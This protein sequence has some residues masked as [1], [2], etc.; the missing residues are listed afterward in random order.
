M[1]EVRDTAKT[2]VEELSSL[3]ERRLDLLREAECPLQSII[4]EE[5]LEVAVMRNGQDGETAMDYHN[6]TLRQ[7]A[8]EFQLLLKDKH[9]KL[10]DLIDQWTHTQK[11]LLQTTVEIAGLERLEL[12]REQ[13][14]SELIAA[15]A[16]GDK[17]R[18]RVGQQHGEVLLELEEVERQVRDVTDQTK[19]SLTKLA[20]VLPLLPLFRSGLTAW[21]AN[22]ARSIKPDQKAQ[23]QSQR[24]HGR[25]MIAVRVRTVT[26][27]PD[28]PVSA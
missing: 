22:S 2:H 8:Q 6:V 27:C 13:A 12:K 17:E 9:G 14:Y 7:R 16:A 15:L 5:V 25:S 4:S 26:S 3:F 19:N 11:E 10:T 23:P 20:K 18:A 21:E 28:L 1:T 24:I